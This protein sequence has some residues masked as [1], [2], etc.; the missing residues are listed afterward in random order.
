MRL[1][2]TTQ[3][4]HT[5]SELGKN[6]CVSGGGGCEWVCVMGSMSERERERKREERN[7]RSKFYPNLHM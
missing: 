5:H 1:N 2:L 7:E 3:I 6:V 4:T